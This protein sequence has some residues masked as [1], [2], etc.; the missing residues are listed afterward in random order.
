MGRKIR[1]RYFNAGGNNKF[2]VILTQKIHILI[3]QKINTAR[4]HTN[5][6]LKP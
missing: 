5:L 3:T 1:I 6:L 2:V 4:I